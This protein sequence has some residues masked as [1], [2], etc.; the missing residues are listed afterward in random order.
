M[1][2]ERPDYDVPVPL[3]NAPPKLMKADG[4]AGRRIAMPAMNQTPM[5]PESSLF[6]EEW[7]QAFVIIGRQTWKEQNWAKSSLAT[8]QDQNSPI[9]IATDNRGVAVKVIHPVVAPLR[10]FFCFI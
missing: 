2:R 7:P 9:K 3:R 1:P 6:P 10:P 5:P 4:L 8:E